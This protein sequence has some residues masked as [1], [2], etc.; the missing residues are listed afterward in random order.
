MTRNR[1]IIRLAGMATLLLTA[2]ALAGC[3]GSSNSSGSNALP[4]TAGGQRAT[5]GVANSDVGKILVDSQ[6]RTLY[7]FGKDSGSKSAC[8]GACASEWPPLRANGKPTEGSG[9]TASLVATTA[10]PDGTSQVTYSGHPL[11]RFVGDKKAGDTNGV[12]LNAFG[13]VWSALS[14]TG[15]E[16]ST[17]HKSGGGGGGYGY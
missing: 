2:L 14:P 7:L 9:A 17:P 5:L 15:N 13:G 10:R 11:Y 12:G 8:T 16:I 3:G 6:G 1:S 4:T